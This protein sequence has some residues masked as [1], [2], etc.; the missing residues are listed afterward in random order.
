VENAIYEIEQSGYINRKWFEKTFPKIANS[1]P[2]NYTSIGGV[3]QALDY[4]TYVESSY[5]KIVKVFNK[6]SY[7]S[8]K[9][10]KIKLS[11]KKYI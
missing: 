10:I 7:I 6:K 9:S 4:V 11:K 1:K 3:L 8:I 5:V 2:C